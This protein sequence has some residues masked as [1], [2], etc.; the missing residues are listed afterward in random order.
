MALTQAAPPRKQG[1]PSP[2]NEVLIKVIKICTKIRTYSNN[3]YIYIK[4]KNKTCLTALVFSKNTG[5]II[6]SYKN[7]VVCD[8]E[9]VR[10][11]WSPPRKTPSGIVCEILSRRHVNQTHGKIKKK[12]KICSN[13]FCTAGST[14][15]ELYIIII[16]S[17]LDVFICH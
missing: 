6:D 14:L 17:I 12:G 13:Y 7:I 15:K 9:A 1:R 3:I 2:F 5:L 10:Y 4:N 16:C 8:R 11:K